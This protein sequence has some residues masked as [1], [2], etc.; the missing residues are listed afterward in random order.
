[1]NRYTFFKDPNKQ[2][3]QT[4]RNRATSFAMIRYFV[5]AYIVYLMYGIVQAEIAGENAM[6][7]GGVVAACLILGAGVLF[8]VIHTTI[9]LIKG[10]KESEITD[11]NSL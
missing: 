4:K 8:V 5:C 11:E 2:Y 1:M 9:Y 3:D 6:S 7:I 10:L